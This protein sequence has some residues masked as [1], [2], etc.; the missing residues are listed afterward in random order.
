MVRCIGPYTD[1]VGVGASD[2]GLNASR[3]LHLYTGGDIR[4]QLSDNFDVK[5]RLED[6]FE[7][8]C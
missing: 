3:R 7:P 4:S 1:E 6:S 8:F 2:V 5:A